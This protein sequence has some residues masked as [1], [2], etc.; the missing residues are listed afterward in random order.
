MRIQFAQV[1]IA[2]SKCIYPANMYTY[3]ICNMQKK[4][5][6]PRPHFVNFGLSN[7]YIIKYFIGVFTFT[8][9]IAETPK[10]FP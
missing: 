10:T 1:V 6:L 9:E 5:R 3:L 2:I 4:E 8:M 7:V